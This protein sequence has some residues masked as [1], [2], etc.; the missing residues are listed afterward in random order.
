MA[1]TS[2]RPVSWLITE[3]GVLQADREALASDAFLARLVELGS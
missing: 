3:R 2:R 1:S